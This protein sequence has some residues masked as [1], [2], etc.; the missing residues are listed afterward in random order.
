MLKQGRK[1]AG[2]KASGFD[3]K[4]AARRGD[5]MPAEALLLLEDDLNQR[6]ALTWHLVPVDVRVG[7]SIYDM[8]SHVSRFAGCDVNDAVGRLR[9]LLS[10]RVIS[11]SG[12]VD[13][14]AATYLAQKAAMRMKFIA[15]HDPIVLMEGWVKKQSP[16]Q[17]REWLASVKPEMELTWDEDAEE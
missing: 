13:Q 14:L 10:M 1:A 4:V 2:G 16:E 12:Y 6:I 3:H 7:D 17:L 9:T 5:S 15:S 8:A 11:V